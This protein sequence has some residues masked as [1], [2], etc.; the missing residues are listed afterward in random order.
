MASWRSATY[1]EKWLWISHYWLILEFCP[2]FEHASFHIS[3]VSYSFWRYILPRPHTWN[4]AVISGIMKQLW[5][6][7]THRLC[8]KAPRQRLGHP[9]KLPPCTSQVC[10]RLC[11]SSIRW[12]GRIIPR[13]RGYRTTRRCFA[14]GTTYL[15]WVMPF[16]YLNLQ[17]VLPAY[18]IVILWLIFFRTQAQMKARV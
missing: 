16:F 9:Q 7:K 17:V 11:N 15:G 1:T 14:L 18:Y 6:L 12:S 8:R 10:R 5:S 3:N 2:R 13:V 4:E